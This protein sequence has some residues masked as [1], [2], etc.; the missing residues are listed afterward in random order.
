MELDS[1]TKITRVEFFRKVVILELW[2]SLLSQQD[3]TGETYE[4]YNGLFSDK[5][6]S[7]DLSDYL[8]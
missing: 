7:K 1:A 8:N 6:F 3:Y 5:Q 2:S 4:T